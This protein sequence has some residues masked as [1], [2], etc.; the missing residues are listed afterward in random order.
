MSWIKI[1]RE[2]WNKPWSNKP[3]FLALWLYLLKEAVHKE[4]QRFWNGKTIK[5]KP[6]QFI[7]GRSKIAMDTGIHRS[8]VERVLKCFE[9]EQQIEQQT[10][11]TS[12]LITIVNWKK[13]QTS[14]QPFEPKVSSKRATSEQR[15]STIQEY[16]EYKEDKKGETHPLVLFIRENYPMISQIKRQLTNQE[17][18]KLKDQYSSGQIK[19]VL[20]SMENYKGITKYNSVYLTALKWLAKDFPPSTKSAMTSI[21][22][23]NED[24]I[25][26]KVP[27]TEKYRDEY[28][29]T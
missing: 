22:Y 4:E 10:S 29:G 18:I 24:A 5:I 26:Y 1:H 17:A 7:T 14:E 19:K 2:L 27:Q 20:D 23:D 9:T 25:P 6:G 28:Y 16:K 21:D 11:S 15:V 3:E 12:R 13:Y 8:K